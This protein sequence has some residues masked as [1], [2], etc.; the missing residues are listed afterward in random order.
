MAS[1]PPTKLYADRKP[2]DLEP[3]YARHMN[4]MT[5]EGLHEKSAI[6]EELAFRDQ[7]IE[8]AEATLDD[9]ESA[10]Q[11]TLALLARRDALLGKCLK[12]IIWCS[13][14]NDFQTDGVASVGW[15]RLCRPLI[16]ELQDALGEHPMKAIR[17]Q[18]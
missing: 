1:P 4:A 2:W 3:H 8:A 13:G 16:Q 17:V 6:A 7:V 15:E 9:E 14:S 18:P 12:A 11:E 10:H 5:A